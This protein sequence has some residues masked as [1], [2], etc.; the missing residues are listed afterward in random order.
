MTHP[1]EALWTRH[2]PPTGYPARV[3]RVRAPIPGVAFFPGGYGLRGSEAG[4]PLPTFPVGGV[5]V[6]GHDF[7]SETGY[8][9]SLAR[10]HEPMTQPTW[11]NLNALLGEV[12]I[13][14]ERCFYTNLYMGLREG[15]GTTGVFPGAAD[16][17]FVAHCKSFLIEQLR[18][19]RPSLVLT[20]GV[21]VP[22]VVGVMSPELEVW[23]AGRG[24]KHLDTVGPVRANV[25]WH[26][27]DDFTTT[28]VALI[29]PSLRHASVRHRRYR[30]LVGH[31]A[32][33]RMIEDALALSG[34]ATGPRVDASEGRSGALR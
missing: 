13:P 6:L 1:V 17:A 4:Q 8:R 26:G 21:Q 9:E 10:G 27:A 20:L 30:E 25:T 34:V 12:G 15:T 16:A 23:S 5:M 24:L 14:P 19:Q 33:V 2:H 11:R 3:V 32:E 18:A 29:H 7:H 31:A 28:V 22:P